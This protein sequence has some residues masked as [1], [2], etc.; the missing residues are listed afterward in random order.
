MMAANGDKTWDRFAIFRTAE[1]EVSWLD[2]ELT[3]GR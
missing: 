1:A 2:A 3:E